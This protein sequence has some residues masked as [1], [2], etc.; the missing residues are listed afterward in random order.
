MNDDAECVSV[1]SIL[2]F[3]RWLPYTIRHEN[4]RT[5]DGYSE[6]PLSC[7]KGP[8]HWLRSWRATRFGLMYHIFSHVIWGELNG[9]KL[10]WQEKVDLLAFK[11]LVI[12]LWLMC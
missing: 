2:F 8:S 4:T 7:Q 6:K 12:I 3:L 10:F 1:V 9:S 11:E 5:T